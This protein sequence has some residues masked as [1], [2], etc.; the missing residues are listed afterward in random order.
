MKIEIRKFLSD[1]TEAIFQEIDQFGFIQNFTLVGGSG[2]SYYLNHRLSE[3][4]DYF[5]W[6]STLNKNEIDKFLRSISKAHNLTILNQSPSEIDLL[7]DN[8]KIT[9]FA[10]D[11]LELKINRQKI[12]KNTFVA[13]IELLTAMKINVL[14]ARAKFRDY[15]DLYVLAKE[16]YNID[17]IYDISKNK[18]PGLTKKIFAMQIS[19]I[20]DIDDEGIKH[21]NPKY[22]VTLPEIHKYFE[23]QVSAFIKVK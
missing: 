13:S 21:L 7:I 11:W 23:E 5:S 22:N 6:E 4:L 1:Q 8:I 9:F 19:Y 3:D 18:I 2:L 12:L 20:E 10:N 16:R 14:S 17:Q 15:Y